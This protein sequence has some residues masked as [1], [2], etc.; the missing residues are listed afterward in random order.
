M[1]TSP[2]LI[3]SNY[4]TLKYCLIFSS[5]QLS[6]GAIYCTVYTQYY[7]TNKYAVIKLQNTSHLMLLFWFFFTLLVHMWLEGFKQIFFLNMKKSNKSKT[8]IFH[9][10]FVAFFVTDRG[11]PWHSHRRQLSIQGR[12]PHIQTCNVAVWIY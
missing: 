8:K 2:D 6:D 3:S 9:T 4:F 1:L 5:L 10:F 12:G 7:F 11:W